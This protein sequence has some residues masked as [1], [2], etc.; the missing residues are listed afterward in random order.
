MITLSKDEV[1]QVQPLVKRKYADTVL[2]PATGKERPSEMAGKFYWRCS[3]PKGIFTVEDGSPLLEDIRKGDV[4]ELTLKANEQN[5]VSY[6]SHSTVT[7]KV[8]RAEAEGKIAQYEKGNFNFKS[9][10]PE[11]VLNVGD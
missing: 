6:L 11:E 3:S 9:V 2:D 4:W 1:L 7:A 8:R 10:S 5:Q